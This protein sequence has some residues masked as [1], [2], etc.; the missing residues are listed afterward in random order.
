MV[1]V[2]LKDYIENNLT[3]SSLIEMKE[4]QSINSFSDLCKNINNEFVV[5]A[6]RPGNGKTSILYKLLVDKL[7]NT[8]N[9][10][11][12]L[13]LHENQSKSITEIIS[14][15]RNSDKDTCLNNIIVNFTYNIE[16][17]HHAERF[18]REAI[19]KHKIDAVFIDNIFILSLL[20]IMYPFIDEIT[21]NTSENLN[22]YLDPNFIRFI[23]YLL[24]LNKGN[25]IPV[26]L[27]ENLISRYFE[28]NFDDISSEELKSIADKVLLVRR[29]SFYR[30]S[31]DEEGNDITN[32]TEVYIAKNKS[33]NSL[34]KIII[35]DT[36]MNVR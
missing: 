8:K 19:L 29:P 28:S 15:L 1:T 5:I 4:K 33:G 11:L 24:E 21:E 35:E 10:V 31:E 3:D 9:K 14:L 7:T 32:I 36:D 13:S 27:T 25:T 16:N 12:L 22:T 17:Y 34:N 6:G 18:I 26:Y 30:I 20:D 23:R 2:T